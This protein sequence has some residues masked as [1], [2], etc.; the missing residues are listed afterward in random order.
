MAALLMEAGPASLIRGRDGPVPI[1]IAA[2]SISG[3]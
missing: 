3:A 1:L 2:G